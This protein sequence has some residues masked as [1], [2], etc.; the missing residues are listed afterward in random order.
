LWHENVRMYHVIDVTS[1]VPI[2]AFTLDLY[3]APRKRRPGFWTE[4]ALRYSEELGSHGLPRRP[5]V[6]IVG[7][8]EP[9]RGQ[10][11]VA[12]MSLGQVQSLFR[13][14][15]DALQELLT[16]QEEGLMAGS[17]G[18]E[19]DAVGFPGHFLELWALDRET[20]QGMGL[21]PEDA[22]AAAA[23]R[24]FHSGARISEE[25]RLALTDLELHARYT[26][27]GDETSAD[28]AERIAGQSV[29]RA[30]GAEENTLSHFSASFAS[31]FAAGY[32]ADLWAQVLAADAFA[33]FRGDSGGDSGVDNERL[34]RQFRSSVLAHG[35]GR[36]P[37][38]NFREFLGRSPRIAPLLRSWGLSPPSRPDRGGDNSDGVQGSS[39][40]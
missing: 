34:G 32:Y 23:T 5:V 15:G 19:L 8:V 26:P 16:E 39:A 37:T 38:T 30:L 14:F 13:A 33:A 17:R 12:R 27:G 7:D 35:G 10:R 21:S 3:R 24:R 29:A 28:V 22:E 11:K 20:L 1:R 4:V 31:G 9:A 40:G 6:H 18:L 2:G 25:V 36:S